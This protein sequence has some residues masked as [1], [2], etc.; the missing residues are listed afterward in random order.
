MNEDQVKGKAK[1]IG[2][3][4]QEEVGKVIGSSEQQAKGLSKQVEGK[5][6][7]KFG[8]AKEVLK[9]QGNR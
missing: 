7:E 1:D 9:D 4:I 6:Q 3:K 2:G 8:D 5:T